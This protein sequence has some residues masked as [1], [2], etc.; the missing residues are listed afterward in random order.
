MKSKYKL[1]LLT[2]ILCIAILIAFG[3]TN[4]DKTFVGYWTAD[5][6]KVRTV[7]FRDKD[8]VFQMVIWDSSDGEEVEVVKLQ[9]TE[10]TIK[11]TEKVVST[12]WVTYNTYSNVDEN[13]LKCIVGGDASSGTVIYLKRFK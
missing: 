6:S 8:D 1:I 12:N 4:L 13:T 10:K 11:T 3:Q 2:A 7:I 9:V 5:D